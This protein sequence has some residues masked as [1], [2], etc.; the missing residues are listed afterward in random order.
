[1]ESAIPKRDLIIHAI[2]LITMS[3]DTPGIS[4]FNNEKVLVVPDILFRDNLGSEGK[5]FYMSNEEMLIE[6]RKN[7]FFMD[8]E[9]AEQDENYR[10]VIPYVIIRKP[11]IPP[12]F[13][14]FKRLK[15]QG[16]QRLHN[17]LSLGAGGHIN[18]VDY[19]AADPLNEGLMREIEEEIYPPEKYNLTFMGWIYSRIDPV[20]CVHAGM[21]YIMD[22]PDGN[23]RIRETDKMTGE[24]CEIGDLRQKIDQMEGWSR[25]IMQHLILV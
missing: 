23:I 17:L 10:Q 2:M 9:Q 13:F 7:A 5:D 18:P 16:E 12:R 6:I 25:I 21:V 14:L 3:K 15:T 1:L 22:T 4:K 8:R 24:W 19:K 20:A 11:G